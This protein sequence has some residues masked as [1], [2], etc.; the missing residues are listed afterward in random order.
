M[1]R[2][3][4]PAFRRT[5]GKW[6]A[7]AKYEGSTKKAEAFRPREKGGAR[8]NKAAA[9]IVPRVKVFTRSHLPVLS[10]YLTDT[11]TAVLVGEGR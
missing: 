2:S 8:Q 5:F 6:L 1:S 9:R 4:L 11:R 3:I 10:T 7:S